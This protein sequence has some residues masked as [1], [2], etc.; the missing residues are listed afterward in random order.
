M[1]PA[2]N[3]KWCFLKE[4]QRERIK[5]INEKEF[6]IFGIYFQERYDA[7]IPILGNLLL[8]AKCILMLNEFANKIY[9]INQSFDIYD[10]F[11]EKACL[12]GIRVPSELT[13]FSTRVKATNNFLSVRSVIFNFVLYSQNSVPYMVSNK[14]SVTM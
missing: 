13:V 9:S 8:L 1:L 14:S 4:L 3:F 11:S 10:F 6:E 7:F 2:G 12:I 5:Q